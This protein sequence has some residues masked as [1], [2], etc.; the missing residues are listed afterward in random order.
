MRYPV[1]FQLFI[2]SLFLLKVHLYLT[3]AFALVSII[4]R[5][6]VLTIYVILDIR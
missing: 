5:V 3:V 6:V 1:K 4:V 2:Q